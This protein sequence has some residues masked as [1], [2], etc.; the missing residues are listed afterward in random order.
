MS[1]TIKMNQGKWNIEIKDEKF[2]FEEENQFKESLGALLDMKNKHKRKE[3][4]NYDRR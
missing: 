1:I 4:N 2:Y 3:D